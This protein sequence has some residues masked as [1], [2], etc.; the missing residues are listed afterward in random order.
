M[1]NKVP[2]REQWKGHGIRLAKIIYLEGGVAGT[3]A[4]DFDGAFQFRVAFNLAENAVYSRSLPLAMRSVH[5][6]NLDN[7]DPGPYVR[8][9]E[10]AG[11]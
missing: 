8:Y 7:D 9:A 11:G 4:D 5:A 1:N 6:E 3:D 2:V 10:C